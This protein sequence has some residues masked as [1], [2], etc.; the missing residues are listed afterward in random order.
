MESKLGL[1]DESDAEETRVLTE[2]SVTKRQRFFRIFL[3]FLYLL[4]INSI[5][6]QLKFKVHY[7]VKTK[8][9]L[10]NF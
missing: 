9:Y 7:P 10:S 5:N 6:S 1:N 4:I 2:N 3:I 8:F